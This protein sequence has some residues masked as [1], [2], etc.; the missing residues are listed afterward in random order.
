MDLDGYCS[1]IQHSLAWSHLGSRKPGE[2]HGLFYILWKYL[3]VDILLFAITL[4]FPVRGLC[5]PTFIDFEVWQIICFSQWTVSGCD[6]RHFCAE[7]FRSIVFLPPYLLFPSACFRFQW[8]LQ[9]S[10]EAG[11]VE[12]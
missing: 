4:Q 11:K 2:L 10:N 8:L 6:L 5:I 9:F 1:K 12:P 7:A 3:V